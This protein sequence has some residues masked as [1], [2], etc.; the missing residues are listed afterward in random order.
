MSWDTKQFSLHEPVLYDEVMWCLMKSDTW[1]NRIVDA[2]LGLGWHAQG[3]LER[4]HTDDIFIGIDRDSENLTKARALLPEHS[5]IRSYF[6]HESFQNI[7]AVLDQVNVSEVT[8]I[9]YD[10]GVSS[11]HYDEGER[12]FSFRSD[13]VLDMRFDRNTGKMAR[14]LLSEKDERS[15]TKIF[16]E[17]W[18]EPRAYAIAQAII[19]A[20]KNG[21]PIHTTSELLAL[22]QWSSRDPKSPT[23]VFQALRI[24]VNEEFAHIEHSLHE[25][26]ARIALHGRIAVITFHS[27]EDRLVKHIFAQYEKD[28]IDEITGQT[29]IPARLQKVNKKPIIPSE[30]EIRRN[31]RSRSAKLRIVERIS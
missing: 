12:G 13:A 26:I 17:Y 3:I 15:L 29:R 9:L 25:A 5:W 1:Q 6:F 2:T 24:A 4:M 28:T 7:G 23:R 22:I 21:I 10:L 20:Q 18:E 19:H 11:V 8:G 27:V 31:P 16:R 30:E 14:D